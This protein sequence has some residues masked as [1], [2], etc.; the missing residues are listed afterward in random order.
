[1][2]THFLRYVP[3]SLIL[4]ALLVGLL[5]VVIPQSE[6]TH[7]VEVS[8]GIS[9]DMTSGI[10]S[11]NAYE[12]KPLSNTEELGMVLYTNYVLAFELAAV[13]LLVAIIAAISL[14]HR[15]PMR[16]KTQDVVRQIMT[17]RDERVT[18]VKMKSEK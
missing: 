3:F 1:M 9:H 15:R 2:R 5:L 6:F 17:M 11:S 14:V 8:T 13:I 4:V 12:L 7:G 18:L 10:L 16:S